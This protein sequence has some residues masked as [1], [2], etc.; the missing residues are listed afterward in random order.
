MRLA[1]APFL[2][3][4]VIVG[5]S[6]AGG[7]K[8]GESGD[9]RPPAF[10]LML[11]PVSVKQ[12]CQSVR[13]RSAQQ[14][15]WRVVC[16]PLVPKSKRPDVTFA[17]GVLSSTNYGPGYLFDVRDAAGESVYAGH[18]TFASGRPAAVHTPL[19]S[20]PGNVIKFTR[21]RANL[22]GQRV[23][24]FRVKPGLTELSGHVVVEW[25]WHGQAYQVSVHRWRSDR[26]GLEQATKMATA[27]IRQLRGE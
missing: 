3:V 11:A 14:S 5:C 24:V 25:V 13:R 4:F 9:K 7:P 20:G 1:L 10:G 23:L 8:A 21:T 15:D 18:W 16:P 19:T 6:D 17:G 2:I 27:I 12:A 26:Q 22:V